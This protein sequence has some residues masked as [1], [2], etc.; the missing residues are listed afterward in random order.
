MVAEY[1]NIPYAGTEN[2]TLL[3]D[4][5]LPDNDE[6]PYLVI[7]VHGGAW[8]FGSKEDPPMA[9]VKTAY[10]MASIDFRQSSE[11]IFPAQIHDIKAAIRFLR[12]NAEQ[13]GYR[14]DKSAV[15]GA[16]AG[17][18]LAARRGTT[19]GH[20]ILEGD[21]GEHSEQSSDV[22]AIIDYYG[23]TNFLTIFAQST[24]HGLSVRI[25]ALTALLGKPIETPEVQELAVLASP[26]HQVNKLAAPIL[27]MHGVQDDQVPINQSLELDGVYKRNGLVSQIEFIEGAGHMDSVYYEPQ[28]INIID[29]FLTKV[30]D[31]AD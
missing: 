15:W 10:A 1:K 23:P 19:N 8:Q 4:L 20:P 13:Y 21:L 11:A 18:H 3:L 27:I 29:N 22:Q 28:Y 2:K 9:L 25:P 24:P 16:S 17:G 14:S 7:W 31:I 26:V 6:C 30:F 5:Y 12:A